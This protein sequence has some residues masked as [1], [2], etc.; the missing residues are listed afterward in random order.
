MPTFTL[1]PLLTDELKAVNVLLNSI[2]EAPVSALEPPMGVDAETAAAAIAEVTNAV[3]SKG[4]HFNRDDCTTLSPNQEGAI[5]L[6]ANCLFV[7]TAYGSWRGRVA[8]R[9]RM[10]WNKRKKTF[11]FTE[12][13]EVDLILRLTWE[14]M[15]EYARRYI[16]IRAAQLFQG[17]VQ[18]DRVVYTVQ[19]SEVDDALATLE[20]R[21]D[22]ANPLNVLTGN[23]D[24]AQK[25]Y[26][27]NGLRRRT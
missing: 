7:G 20:N 21:E 16:T 15:P 13:V 6:P 1:P 2:A 9:N 10:L 23:L 4:Y 24:T 19:A 14:E 8:E 18:N 11:T 3:L 12:P 22:E 27:R 5:L 17:R 26:G 25:V